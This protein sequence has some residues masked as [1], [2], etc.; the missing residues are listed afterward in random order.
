M[1]CPFLLCFVVYTTTKYAVL[2]KIPK[3]KFYKNRK[4]IK[5]Y[6]C[7]LKLKENGSEY[8]PLEIKTMLY[9]TLFWSI[10]TNTVCSLMYNIEILNLPESK[11]SKYYLGT[12][13]LKTKFV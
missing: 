10:Y 11:K 1:Q 9:S 13:M 8:T 6:L 3:F 4:K 5:L 2:C 12:P 7:T